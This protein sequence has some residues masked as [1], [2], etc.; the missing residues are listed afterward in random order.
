[1]KEL[2]KKEA[3]MKQGNRGVETEEEVANEAKKR[4]IMWKEAINENKEL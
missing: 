1:M 2:K 4:F 3:L